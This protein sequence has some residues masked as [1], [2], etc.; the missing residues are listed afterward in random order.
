MGGPGGIPK[1]RVR[2]HR[3]SRCRDFRW[4]SGGRQHVHIHRLLHFSGWVRSDRWSH[5]SILPGIK[6]QPARTEQN[7]QQQKDGDQSPCDPVQGVFRAA[8][9]AE[10]AGRSAN[11]HAP[12]AVPLRAMEEN[13]N[14]QKGAGEKPGDERKRVKQPSLK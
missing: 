13:G 10:H 5:N 14:D 8:G 11:G 3:D 9:T 6:L 12:H 1:E 4:R 2:G 7:G